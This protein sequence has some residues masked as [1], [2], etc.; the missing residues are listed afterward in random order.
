MPMALFLSRS[1]WFA[2]ANAWGCAKHN[3]RSGVLSHTERSSAASPVRLRIPGSYHL[4][5]GTTLLGLSHQKNNS[6]PSSGCS[7]AA[8]NLRRK[9]VLLL[10]KSSTPH[11]RLWCIAIMARGI[12][13][14]NVLF[15]PL[16]R[17]LEE[18]PVVALLT[19]ATAARAASIGYNLRRFFWTPAAL[20]SVKLETRSVPRATAWKSQKKKRAGRAGR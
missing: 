4:I 20:S 2:H 8:R 11:Q 10:A 16:Q 18:L 14:L 15:G 13:G 6:W 7:G 9:V 5:I 1:N 19:R 17:I 12:T 3:G